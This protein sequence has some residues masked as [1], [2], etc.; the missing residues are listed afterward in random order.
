[1]KADGGQSFKLQ[2]S[3]LREA[4]SFKLKASPSGS[5]LLLGVCGLKFHWSLKLGA[6]SFAL[7]WSLVLGCWSFAASASPGTV[8][9]G[10]NN[11][12]RIT[13]S[14]TGNPVT[15]ADNV[16]AALYWSALGSNN[17]IQLGAATSVGVPVDGVFADG[18]RTTGPETTGGSQAQFRV[19]AWGGGFGTFEEAVTNGS[20]N[21]IGQSA[22]IRVTTG[23]PGGDP[24]TPPASLFPYGVP[25]FPLGTNGLL[26]L[27]LTCS[28][29]KTVS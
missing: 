27:T 2:T 7:L 14:V 4:S 1:M 19:R 29:N 8:T 17:F 26:V 3:S 28:T 10:N 5:A 11:A 18:T 12:S 16:K 13:N 23:N 20:G 6:W 9:F 22:I 25:G 21:L 24:P 15:L